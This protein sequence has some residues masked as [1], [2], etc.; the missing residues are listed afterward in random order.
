MFVM[1][2]A[3]ILRDLVIG[4]LIAGAIGAWEGYSRGAIEM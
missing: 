2:W 4:L 3:T 1:E